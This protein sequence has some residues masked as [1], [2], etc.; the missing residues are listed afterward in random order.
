MAGESRFGHGD[1][2]PRPDAERRE[3]DHLGSMDYGGYPEAAL[4]HGHGEAA[5]GR[6][7]WSERHLGYGHGGRIDYGGYPR[8]VLGGGRS[9]GADEPGGY[10][11]GGDLEG[12][13]EHG[14]RGPLGYTRSDERIRED[15][16]D[17]LTGDPALDA[18][19][20]EVQVGSGEV[21]LSGTVRSRPDKRLAG[22][23][24]GEISGVKHVQNNLRVPQAG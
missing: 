21:T 9:G 4:G 17:R 7:R 3:Y 8:G 1:D 24:A 10:G 19:G 16:R 2:R 14:G 20:I 12:V 13:G 5:P 11:F 22:D 6:Y 23:I 15:V 18:S